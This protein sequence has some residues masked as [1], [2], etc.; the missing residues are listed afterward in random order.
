MKFL[1]SPKRRIQVLIIATVVTL[2]GGYLAVELTPFRDPPLPLK[3]M[4]KVIQ[5]ETATKYREQSAQF[6]DW[7]FAVLAGAIAIV[8]TT[9]VHKSKKCEQLYIVLGPTAALLLM[10]LR[11]GYQ[12]QRRHTNLIAFDDFTDLP[13]LAKLLVIQWRL[14]FVALVFASLFALRYLM[15]IVSGEIKPFEENRK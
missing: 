12:F 6:S 7:A 2:A 3:P 8:I 10:S 9:K 13:S 5:K 4:T 11:A 14:F 1:E 15:L